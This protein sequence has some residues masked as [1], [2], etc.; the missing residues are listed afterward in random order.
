M[1]ILPG[2]TVGLTVVGCTIGFGV[3]RTSVGARD[4]VL[5]V[6]DVLIGSVVGLLASHSV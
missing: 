1:I 4:D 5:V 3:V 2:G 6:Y